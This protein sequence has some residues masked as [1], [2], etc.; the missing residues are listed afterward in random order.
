VIRAVLLAGVQVLLRVAFGLYRTPRLDP[1]CIVVSNHNS[2]LDAYV[3][4]LLFGVRALPGVRAAAAADMFGTGLRAWGA[5][6]TLDPILVQR[7]VRAADPLAGVRAALARGDSLLIFPEGTRGD[8][9]VIEPFKPGVGEIAR[10][11]PEVPVYPCFIAGIERVLPRGA[12]LPLP[13]NV[14]I[15][16][17]EPVRF[18]ASQHRR[19]IAKELENRVRGLAAEYARQRMG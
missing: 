17:G 4:T 8:P 16:V 19:A 3:L 2:F 13:F 5:R 1:P 6:I 14:E 10:S 18:D 11:F 15:L 9:G 12:W 7:R